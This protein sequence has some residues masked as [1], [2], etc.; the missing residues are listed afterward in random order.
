LR[1]LVLALANARVTSPGRPV[2]W[3]EL[4]A[5]GWPGEK[6]LQDA[7]RNRLYMMISRIREVGV[8]RA[9]R[10]EGDGYLLGPEVR[11]ELVD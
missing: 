9:L 1:R 2:P 7:A 4:V 8:G 3:S 10:A 6:I 11:V 5:H